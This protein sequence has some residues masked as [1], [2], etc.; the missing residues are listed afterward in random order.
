MAQRLFSKLSA[1]M[2]KKIYWLTFS[3]VVLL[4]IFLNFYRLR[5]T[6][7]FF[8]D[9]ARDMEVVRKMIVDHKWTLL[10]PT[11]S[12]G[13]G[14]QQESYFGPFYYYLIY[15]ALILSKLDPVGPAYLTAIFGTSAAVLL[16]FFLLKLTHHRWLSLLGLF[17]YL[18]SPLSVEYS[19]FPWNPNFISFFVIL[20]LII[21]EAFLR[22]GKM[23]LVLGIGFIS[24]LIFQLHY[25]S[26][27]IISAIFISLLIL[28]PKKIILTLFNFVF[29]F[30]VGIFPLV[31]FELRHNF[32]LT[33]GI[34]KIANSG[35]SG[36]AP[37]FLSFIF[38]LR[39]FIGRF[40]G[41][42]NYSLVKM[43]KSSSILSLA[44]ML[45]SLSLIFLFFYSQRH[46]KIRKEK[47]NQIIFVLALSFI[48]GLL[49]AASFVKASD[50][51]KIEDRYLLPIF[52]IFLSL[53][54][55]SLGKL[56][57]LIK[58]KKKLFLILLIILLPLS[59]FALKKDI[60][61]ISRII[62][63]DFY[64]VN[65]KGAQQIAQIVADD[66]KEN[67]FEGKFN[68]ANI[69]DGNTRATYY[70]YFLNVLGVKPLAVEAYP[71]TKVLYVISLKSKEQTLIY[72]VWEINSFAPKKIAKE[73]G[74]DFDVKIYRLEN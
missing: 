35:L 6:Q 18:I 22:K 17:I 11:S 34:L 52:P 74:T 63:I 10:G 67:K 16:Y 39:S 24:G 21:V 68:V 12:I 61:I 60:K 47:Q 29:G 62:P 26:M 32:F 27:G 71:Q 38:N 8:W 23:L 55:I 1:E 51:P 57:R 41:F 73:W 20:L 9:V 44:L 70:R 19:R 48:L 31:L 14:S 66:V 49:A 40:F 45:I 33:R 56:G 15:P 65:L 37:L 53:F 43:E 64:H 36:N 59:I 30:V 2:N 13:F 54:I 69:V 3:L 46:F 25:I 50:N 42:D 28:K 72:P 7:N 4:G 58:N 5:E